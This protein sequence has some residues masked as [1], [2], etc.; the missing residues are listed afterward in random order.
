[1]YDHFYMRNYYRHTDGSVNPEFQESFVRLSVGYK[2][3]KDYQL[4]LKSDLGKEIQEEFYMYYDNNE[5]FK[6]AKIW[7]TIVT[8][9]HKKN[10]HWFDDFYNLEFELYNW[11]KVEDAQ[12][13]YLKLP[14]FIKD[15]EIDVREQ[16]VYAAYLALDKSVR[17]QPSEHMIEAAVCFIDVEHAPFYCGIETIKASD[18]VEQRKWYEIEIRKELENKFQAKI[19]EQVLEQIQEK[20]QKQVKE[21]QLQAQLQTQLHTKL[22][23]ELKQ[24]LKA[25]DELI[26]KLQSKLINE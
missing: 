9:G 1:M 4:F 26:A 20:I 21:I 23:S 25:Q 18:E 19:H 13:E 11:D 5:M 2:N 15:L 14:E 7:V 22:I 6:V 10:Q 17:S 16:F 12:L 24:Q 8:H 3:D